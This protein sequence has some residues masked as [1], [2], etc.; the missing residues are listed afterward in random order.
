MATQVYSAARS[1]SPAVYAKI[2]VQERR[3]QILEEAAEMRA[4]NPDLVAKFRAVLE[5]LSPEA[6]DA[7][8]SFADTLRS[9]AEYAVDTGDYSR[10]LALPV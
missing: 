8:E 6:C 2:S 5:G 9:E 4:N 1:F 3:Q 10:I 7:L